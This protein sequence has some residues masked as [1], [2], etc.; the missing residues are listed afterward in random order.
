MLTD[1]QILAKQEA[2]EEDRRKLEG[3]KKIASSERIKLSRKVYDTDRVTVTKGELAKLKA[4]YQGE[5]VFNK[6]A[7]ESAL[8]KVD[9]L[10]ALP[11]NMR[12]EI[13]SQLFEGYNIRYRKTGL[14][15]VPLHLSLLVIM[16]F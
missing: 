1:E 6:S 12:K 9:I 4:N 2:L 16:N 7:I 8:S 15:S 3:L 14:N 11:A 10:K 5:K 13:T